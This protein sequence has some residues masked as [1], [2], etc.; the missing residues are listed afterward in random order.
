VRRDPMYEEI[1]V[2]Y[3]KAGDVFQVSIKEKCFF[4]MKLLQG[5]VWVYCKILSVKIC[6]GNLFELF[7]FENEN[8]GTK[9]PSKW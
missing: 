4:G 1:E 2:I 5:V 8:K 7:S 6:T 3:K 9:N